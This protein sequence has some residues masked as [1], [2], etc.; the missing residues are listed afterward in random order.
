M[1]KYE[2]LKRIYES[3]IVVVI[4]AASAGEA[5]NVTEAVRAGGIAA[6]EITMTVPGALEVIREV[7]GSY[8]SSQVLVGAGTVLD[9]ETARQ[10][11]LAGAEFVVSPYFNA[12]VV[13]L[14][15]RYQKICMPGAMSVK[16]IVEIMEAGVDVIKLFPGNAFGP[17][18]IKAI[19]GPLPQ[20]EIMPTG[21]VSLE[22]VDQWIKA[23]AFAVGVGGELTAE[24]LKYG[25]FSMITKTAKAFRDKILQA[26]NN[27]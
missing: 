9:P 20:A 10:V 14:C 13:R 17:G 3:G 23:G 1:A 16:E 4:R 7:A 24:G 2:Q 6:I 11:L 22:N 12:D 8:E 27:R 19:K 21:G 18:M 5:L 25:D 15:N 26:R